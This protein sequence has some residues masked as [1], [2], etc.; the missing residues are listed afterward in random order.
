VAEPIVFIAGNDLV[1]ATGGHASYV[2]AH[3]WAARRAGFEPHLFALSRVA[4]RVDADFGTIHRVPV[5]VPLE[6][7]PFWRHRKNQMVWRYAALARAAAAFGLQHRRVRIVHAFGLF[8]CAG[9]M[10][11]ERCAGTVVT[12]S[13]C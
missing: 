7:L 13:R 12:S 6:Q 1:G 5:R 11:T 4:D 8:G 10:A 2:R 9:V 3:A